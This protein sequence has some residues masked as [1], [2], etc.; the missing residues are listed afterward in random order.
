MI[1]FLQESSALNFDVGVE[2]ESL[3][4]NAAIELVSESCFA[5]TQLAAIKILEKAK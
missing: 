1:C 5:K 2:G 4:G 3:D